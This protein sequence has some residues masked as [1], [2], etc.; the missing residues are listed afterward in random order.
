M[1]FRF[2][3]ILVGLI[4]AFQVSGPLAQ[5]DVLRTVMREKLA[6]TQGLLEAVVR[7]DYVSMA[8]YSEL[9][10]RITYTEIASWQAVAQPDYIR[11]ATQFLTS[12]KGLSDAATRKNADEGAREYATLIGSCVG[13]HTYIRNTRAASLGPVERRHPLLASDR[14]AP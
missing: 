14:V 8:R 1:P 5:S 2:G 10:S 7:A 9:L 11:N 3:V 12:V 6:N 13:C 4:L